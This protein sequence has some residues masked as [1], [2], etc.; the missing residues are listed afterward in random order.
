[1]VC[2]LFSV[3][4]CPSSCSLVENEENMAADTLAVAEGGGTAPICKENNCKNHFFRQTAAE[5]VYLIAHCHVSVCCARFPWGSF[6]SPFCALALN[7]TSPLISILILLFYCEKKRIITVKYFI[8]S[9]IFTSVQTAR[10][11]HSGKNANLNEKTFLV[12]IKFCFFH[13]LLLFCWLIPIILCFSLFA[14]GEVRSRKR[15]CHVQEALTDWGRKVMVSLSLIIERFN[16]L[17][18]SLP[19]WLSIVEIVDTLITKTLSFR[20]SSRLKRS[21]GLG[22]RQSQSVCNF[23]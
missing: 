21:N 14:G 9:S 7:A 16:S 12:V 11:H 19:P 3:F 15:T 13:F 20:S 2:F 17:P 22:G 10:V 6:S 18:S 1:M 23:L 4:R 8:C 5:N